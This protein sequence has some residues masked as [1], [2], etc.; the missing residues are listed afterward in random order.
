MLADFHNSFT[1]TIS[2]KLLSYYRPGFYI[3]IA[4]LPV[5]TFSVHSVRDCIYTS[6]TIEYI[7]VICNVG[8]IDGRSTCTGHLA[9][10]GDPAYIRDPACN[11]L[12]VLRYSLNWHG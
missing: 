12:E 10:I 5:Q 11:V 9:C 4:N 1:T 6:T 8:T 3:N 7:R 2:W